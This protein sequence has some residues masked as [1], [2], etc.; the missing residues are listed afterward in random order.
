MAQT[1]GKRKGA[2]NNVK[3]DKYFDFYGYKVNRFAI[4]NLESRPHW[5]YIQ[6]IDC[7]IEGSFP[8]EHITK[9]KSI[10]NKGVTIWHAAAEVNNYE[11]DNGVSTT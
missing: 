11:L 8:D 3:I 7:N 1:A 10:F 4:P 9:L 5:N 2:I 6:T